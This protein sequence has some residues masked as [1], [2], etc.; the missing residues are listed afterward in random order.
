M[1]PQA[2]IA[3]Q[4]NYTLVVSRDANVYGT[5]YG[6]FATHEPPTCRLTSEMYEVQEY[7]DGLQNFREMMK[8]GKKSRTDDQP[9]RILFNF[10]L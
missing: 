8:Q 9:N 6:L 7:D 1:L 3:K 2:Y 10:D 4:R 5:Y